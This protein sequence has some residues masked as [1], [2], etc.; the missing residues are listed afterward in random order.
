M[1]F[2]LTG[3]SD[4]IDSNIIKQFETLNQLGIQYFEPR[5]INGINISELTDGQVSDLAGNMEKYNIKASSIGSPIGKIKITDD[6]ESHFEKFKRTVG[7]A[8]RINSRYIRIFSFY[9]GGDE[10][11]EKYRDEVMYRLSRFIE[12]AKDNDI[13]LL[14]ENEKGIYGDNAKRC[15]DIMTTLSCENF[16]AVFDPANFV[17]CNQHTLEAFDMLSEFVVYMHIKDAKGKD[18]VPAGYGDGSVEEILKRLKAEN[19][20]GFLSLEPHLGSFEGLA[21][22]ETDNKMTRLSRSSKE[23]FELAH[24]A[25]TDIINRL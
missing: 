5:G 4:E 17:Q 12:N 16:K 25:L 23:K 20:E 10:D 13:I 7:I 1:G 11:A 15:M 18:V 19:F 22:L 24:K 6:F 14:H 8:K 9:I 3:F 2:I 21:A